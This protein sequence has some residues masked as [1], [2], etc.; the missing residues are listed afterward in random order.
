MLDPLREEV[1]EA[2]DAARDAHIKVSIVTG[3]YAVTAKAIA[4]RARL[5]ENP[6]DIV[7][8]SG[9]ELQDLS[10]TQ[11]L[12][13]ARRGGVIFS[14]VAPEDKLRIVQLVQN[15]GQVIAVTGDGIN[16]APA[17][18]RADIGVAMG[19]AGTDVAKQSAEIVLLDDSFH[20][21][22]SAIQQGRTIFQNIKKGTLSCFTS[23]AAELVVNLVSL[24]AAS[25]FH[26]PLALSVM[27][28]LAID[29]IAELFPIAALG[30]DRADG[31]L[32]HTAPRNPHDHIL[33]TKSILDLLWC[34]VLIGGFA[35][36]NYLWFYHRSSVDPQNLP[37]GNLIH[38]K[39]TALTYLTIVLCQLA[40]ILQRRSVGGLFTRYQFHNRQLWL[41]IL[42]SLFCVA[43][44][45]Y[46]PWIAPYFHAGPLSAVDWLYA[47]GAAAIFIIIRELQRH[48]KKHS[49]QAVLTLH[50]QKSL[51]A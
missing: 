33:N 16:D 44:I 47:L 6:D 31:E 21:L 7:V 8:V 38:L 14:R 25:L 19:I 32:M 23:N 36:I 4:M 17:L 30:R 12:T 5:A 40:N 3:D 13:L 28:I 10:D 18:K 22:V 37:A 39:A 2:M 35:Y 48:V 34:G 43:N 27:E 42:F 26:V 11:V 9:E 46:N 1:P 24:A 50:H 49:R 20:T 51:S 45:I 15:S 41:A 29:L